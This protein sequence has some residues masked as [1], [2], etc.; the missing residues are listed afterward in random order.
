MIYKKKQ[1]IAFDT[2][3][4]GSVP[5]SIPSH[6]P[7]TTKTYRGGRGVCKK[8]KEKQSVTNKQDQRQANA[9]RA[10]YYV[11]QR[12]VTRGSPLE[13]SQKKVLR[14]VSTRR[15]EERERNRGR[16]GQ[17]NAPLGDN[18]F[19]YRANGV[20]TN[21]HE[22]VLAK[23]KRRKKKERGACSCFLL[24]TFQRRS[25]NKCRTTKSRRASSH[26]VHRGNEI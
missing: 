17:K 15:S 9:R 18:A 26:F 1:G 21:R 13:P 8:K 12:Q 11:I 25:K 24:N 6:A 16:G 14:A 10:Q 7:N 3:D 2:E 5:Q 22:N 23:K 4:S 20:Q 19:R